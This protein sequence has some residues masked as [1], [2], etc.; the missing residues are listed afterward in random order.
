MTFPKYLPLLATAVTGCLLIS[1]CS[2]S[3]APRG[4]GMA[5]YN[6][7]DRPATLPTNPS[8]VRVKISLSNQMVYVMEG[9][10]ALLVTPCSIG[11]PSTPTPRGHF[12]IFKKD[13]YHRANSHGFAYKG[14]QVR[15]CYLKSKP[16]GWSFKG[17]PM[18][19]WC[20]FKTHYGIHAGW[21]KDRPCTHG[22]V[23][24]HVNVAPKFYRLVQHGTRVHIAHS[25][26]EDA[27]IG[28]NVPRP[29]DATPLPDYPGSL[30]LDN[31]VF[32]MHKKPQ[33]N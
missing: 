9:S 16:A 33:Y 14:D 2:N 30:M 15:Q 13:H 22:C 8:Q 10:K 7:Y 1:S 21:M 20:E 23:R 3:S 27:T 18:P 19:Y 28:R 11:T 17:T 6:A 4:R 5:A 32:T 26:P 31:K 29:P 12:T 24:L 25:Q